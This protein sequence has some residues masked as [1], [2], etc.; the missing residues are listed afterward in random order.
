[1]FKKIEKNNK[2]T[3]DKFVIK[4]VVKKQDE[5]VIP[6]QKKYNLKDVKYQEKDVEVKSKSSAVAMNNKKKKN[7]K[8][9]NPKLKKNKNT[10]NLN[11]N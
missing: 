4:N 9:L 7:K 2:N 8:K 1:M 5:M 3:M 6:I 10:I 11:I